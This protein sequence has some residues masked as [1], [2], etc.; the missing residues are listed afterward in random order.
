FASPP[1]Q[2]LEWSN[3]G[4]EGASRFLRRVWAFGYAQRERIAASFNGEAQ[5]TLNDDQKTLRREVHKVLQQADYDLKRIQY[6]TV[7]SACMK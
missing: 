7:V 4:V 6:N 2:T 1:E 5:G 3:S